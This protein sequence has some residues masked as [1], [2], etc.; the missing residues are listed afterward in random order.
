[1]NKDSEHLACCF[2][3]YCKRLLKH[4]V[5]DAIRE[6][7]RLGQWETTFSE[8]TRAEQSQLQYI[9]RYTPDRRVFPLMGMEIE[10]LDADLVRALSTLP[11]DRRAIILLSYFLEMQDEEI[12]DRLG[13]SRP[14]VQR[15]RT[16]TL[17]M[18]RKILKE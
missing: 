17:D 2:D 12:G 4:E 11:T 9:E 15:R 5:I 8:L 1:M 14:A 10:V 18:L 13:L 16:S 6:Q 7:K 3:A